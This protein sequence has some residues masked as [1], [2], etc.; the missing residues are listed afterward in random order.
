MALLAIRAYDSDS[1]VDVDAD[2]RPPRLSPRDH[3]DSEAQLVVRD[4]MDSL[5]ET[6]CR[7]APRVPDFKA[8]EN[9]FEIQIGSSSGESSSSWS[10]SSGS[11]VEA[12][13]EEERLSQP[14]E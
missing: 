3:L 13:E 1:D 12:V 2:D 7:P 11:D 10:L 6:V 4:I 9:E 5:L 8:C 14:P